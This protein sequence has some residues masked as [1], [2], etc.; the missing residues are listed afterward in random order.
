MGD[1][2]KEDKK[3]K[4]LHDGHR[5][6]VREKI[7]KS[8]IASFPKHEVLEYLLFHVIPRKNT[9]EIAHELINTFGSFSDVL[10]QDAERLMTVK[11]MTKNAAIFL[12][13]LPDVFRIYVQDVDRPRLNLQGKEKAKLYIISEAYGK[14]EEEFYVACLD[15]NDNLLRLEC[16]TRGQGDSVMVAVRQIADLVLRTGA[17]S[18][19]MAHNHPGRTLTPT[20]DDICFTRTALWTLQ[21][22][23]VTVLDHYVV[24]GQD[25]Y[26][27]ADEGMMEALDRENALAR[28]QTQ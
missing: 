25:V 12:S 11:G 16:L 27:F 3:K 5:D 22:I 8:G 21:G 1:S 17:V 10:M 7:M 14:R 18:I 13:S 2:K 6:R 26:S 24:S 20:E 15:V 4:G 9:N 23:G 28:A 19:I